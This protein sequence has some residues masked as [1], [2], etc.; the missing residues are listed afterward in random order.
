MMRI[1]SPDSFKG[2]ELAFVQGMNEPPKQTIKTTGA[3]QDIGGMQTPVPMKVVIAMTQQAPPASAPTPETSKHSNA[4]FI[5]EQFMAARPYSSQ[6]IHAPPP[7]PA[8]A[9]MACEAV[10]PMIPDTICEDASDDMDSEQAAPGTAVWNE[11]LMYANI[12][13]VVSRHMRHIPPILRDPNNTGL[14]MS[15]LD[16][17]AKFQYGPESMLPQPAQCEPP[18]VE[19]IGDWDWLSHMTLR[20][21]E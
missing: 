12:A 6:L 13:R 16:L 11:A 7:S 10:P 9:P 20:D 19:P 21:A 15:P 8:F 5:Y 17:C 1:Y 3:G 14:W 18:C 4:W 2:L